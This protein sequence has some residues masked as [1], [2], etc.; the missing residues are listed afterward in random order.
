MSKCIYQPWG[1]LGD[2]LAHSTIPEL[3]Y[4][5]NIECFLSEHNMYRNKNIY[6]FL[7]ETNPFLQKNKS[8]EKNMNWF[9][10]FPKFTTKES[11][12]I[13]SVE[14]SY[15]FSATNHYPEIYYNPKKLSEFSDKIIVDCK[16]ITSNWDYIIP[17]IYEKIKDYK[18]SVLVVT[19]NFTS[20]KE[21]KCLDEFETIF[22]D[23][24]FYYTDILN[25]VNQIYS[26][27]SGISVLA[28]AIK[29]KYNKELNIN[30]FAPSRF[31]P[32][33]W[34]GGYWFKNTDYIKTD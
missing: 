34:A 4:N 11:N 20:H 9:E 14:K 32:E 22:I 27:T 1:G 5:N 31:C 3:C 17:N 7:W 33:N 23:D 26:V 12:V 25:S 21:N 30:V 29:H 2:N 28:P 6:E 10:V 19:N 16:S 13:E 24:L 8:S 18:S 15:D